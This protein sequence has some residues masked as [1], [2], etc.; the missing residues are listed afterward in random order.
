[1]TLLFDAIRKDQ[2]SKVRILLDTSGSEALSE[3]LTEDGLTPMHVAASFNSHKVVN[4]LLSLN[5]E[6][7][8]ND[9]VSFTPLDLAIMNDAKDTFNL[10]MRTIQCIHLYDQRFSTPL[11]IAAKFNRLE[12]AEKLLEKG[13]SV[14]G[15]VNDPPIF[16]SV[17]GD[18]KAFTEFLLKN[19][20]TTRFKKHGEA[21]LLKIATANNSLSTGKLLLE[22][23]FNV[24]KEH[25]IAREALFEAV[26]SRSYSFI[27][28]LLEYGMS[29][30]IKDEYGSN[31]LFIAA[32]N[33]DT[34]LLNFL[35]DKGIETNIVNKQNATPLHIACASG[36]ADTVDVL[37]RYNL[38]ITIKQ[39]EG[40]TPLHF[41]SFNDDPE[42][43]KLL[44]KHGA[45]IKSRDHKKNTPLHYASNNSSQKVIE[46]LIEHDVKNVNAKNHNGFTP[47]HYAAWCKSADNLKVLQQYGADLNATNKFNSTPL[48]EAVEGNSLES[49]KYLVEQGV[50]LNIKDWMGK[51]CLQLAREKE[52]PNK[53]ILK[54]L[55][56]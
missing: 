13:A 7:N 34:E 11:S 19:N 8:T 33:P 26:K 51:T 53:E 42:I 35:I 3:E 4:L 55:V 22:K 15:S 41:A 56:A 37:I 31:A 10:L 48:M 43:I 9:D 20:A 39:N 49:T 28:L 52:K 45:N 38:D 27:E 5:A 2:E 16:N 18:Y 40:K 29:I 32:G 54:V 23:V 21:T 36:T 30:N 25:D 24:E 17:E 14:D 12:M 1:M 46:L 6:L 47:S 44:I 50:D